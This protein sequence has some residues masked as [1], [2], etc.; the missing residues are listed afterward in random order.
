ITNYLIRRFFQMILVVFFS[1]V[2]IYMLLNIAPGGPLA[3]MRSSGDRRQRPS[4]ADMARL[5]AYLGLNKPILLRYITW[6]VGD[7]WL[8]ADW[9]YMGLGNYRYPKLNTF[10]EQLVL[11]NTSTGGKEPQWEKT[12]FWTDPGPALLNVGY[13]IW[14]W[15]EETGTHQYTADHIQVNP[16]VGTTRPADLT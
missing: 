15:G 12:R 13:P 6:L 16:K 10:G 2:A 3:G 7:D 8:G 14:V 11:T 9:M 5:Q 4:E 1:T